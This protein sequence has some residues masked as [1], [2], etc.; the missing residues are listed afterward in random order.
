MSGNKEQTVMY[1]PGPEEEKKRKKETETRGNLHC[2]AIMVWAS[3]IRA[4]TILMSA[5]MSSAGNCE[6]AMYLEYLD[7]QRHPSF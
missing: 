3:A 2:E 4:R 6:L 1:Q 5:V 7:K